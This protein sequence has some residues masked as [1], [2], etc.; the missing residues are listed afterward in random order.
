VVDRAADVDAETCAAVRLPAP[1]RL[2]VFDLDGTLIDSR[3]DLIQ[4]VNATLQHFG[5][6]ELA[7]DTVT[8]FIGDGATALVR[9]ALAH[10]H[11][12]R[13]EEDP[14]DDV[15]VHS[16][17]A[18]F[19]QYYRVHKLDFTHPYPGVVASLEAIRRAD[20]QLQMAVLTNKPQIPSREICRDLG[21]E[22]F[23]FANYGG[24]SF[25][26]KKPEAE[27]LLRLIDQAAALYGNDSMLPSEVAMVGDSHIDVE[28][29]RACGVWSV[30]CR[31][32]LSP[33]SLEVA[34]PD[35][36]VGSAVEWPGVLGFS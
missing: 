14:H 19:L 3:L 20:P 35:V 2:V 32:G 15:F 18:W 21:L 27:G 4:S 33:G 17:V 11:L 34:G 1:L 12:I 10:A 16:A 22:R 24:D 36:S 7:D 30:G 6:S 5:K 13:D 28:T 29:A 23:F 9:R 26:T 25:A 31:Y 8:S